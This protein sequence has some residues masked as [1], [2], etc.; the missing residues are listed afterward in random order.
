MKREQR[1]GKSGQNVAAGALARAG[2][3]MVEQIGTPI[4]AIPQRGVPGAYHIIWGEKVSGDHRGLLEG[5]GQSVLAETKTI[6]D[7]H[8]RWSDFLPHQPGRLD[9]HHQLGGVSLVVW[10]HSTGV[11]VMRWPIEGFGPGKSISP[12][13]AELLQVSFILER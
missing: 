2:I 1:L 6:L 12:E 4:R 8:L 7:H 3:S 5:T 10:V 9:Y 13:Q 11:Y